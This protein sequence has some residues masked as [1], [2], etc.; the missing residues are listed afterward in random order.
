[1][2]RAFVIFTLLFGFA[3]EAWAD[4]PIPPAPPGRKYVAVYNKVRLGKVFDDYVF[5]IAHGQGPG[6]P[7]YEYTK[8]ELST[9][10]SMS[11]PVGGR[12]QYISLLAVPKGSAD[13][14]P[15]GG[16]L[17][18]GAEWPEKLQIV[19]LH[20]IG[21]GDTETI[22]S[23][24]AAGSLTRTYTITGFGKDRTI[25]T[26]VERDPADPEGK[27]DS[28]SEAEPKPSSRTDAEP[29]EA[30]PGE[31]GPDNTR[32]IV[33]GIAL[34]LSLAVG[35]FLLVRKQRARVATMRD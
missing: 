29:G 17:G 13:K 2:F 26:T 22:D 18:L 25:E 31:T 16:P 4:I 23:K 27:K 3:A 11:M 6:P 21:F 30:Q 9:T 28:A 19:G 8:V 32:S 12:Y 14:V 5:F 24:H 20:Q 10:N 7:R 33:A 1:M 34:A 35:G 15:T